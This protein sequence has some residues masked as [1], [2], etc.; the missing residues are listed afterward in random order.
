MNEIY[1][2][3]NGVEISEIFDSIESLLAELGTSYN[4]IDIKI[5]GQEKRLVKGIDY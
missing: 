3:D 4:F 5:N 1:V 2:L